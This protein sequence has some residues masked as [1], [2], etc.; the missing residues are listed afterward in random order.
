[1]SRCLGDKALASYIELIRKAA[2]RGPGA[3]LFDDDLVLAEALTEELE[4]M[5]DVAPFGRIGGVLRP[6]PL[7]DDDAGQEDQHAPQRHK[8]VGEVARLLQIFLDAGQVPHH[9]W[10]A[11]KFQ[12]FLIQLIFDYIR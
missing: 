9:A 7:D 8:K 4:Q 1:M 5:A 10:N 11:F 6:R 12:S 3:H 2:I